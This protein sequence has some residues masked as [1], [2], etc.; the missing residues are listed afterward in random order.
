MITHENLREKD[1]IIYLINPVKM[2][3]SDWMFDHLDCDTIIQDDPTNSDDITILCYAKNKDF[4]SYLR[5][6]RNKEFPEDK[7]MRAFDSREV[8]GI[9]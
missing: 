7:I 9:D 8:D 3:Y 5:Q 6:V 4:N 1:G 2:N